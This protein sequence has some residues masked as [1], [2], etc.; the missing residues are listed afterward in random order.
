MKNRNFYKSKNFYGSYLYSFLPSLWYQ[1][2][3]SIGYSIGLPPPSGFWI[4]LAYGWYHQETRRILFCDSS[5]GWTLVTSFPPID[6]GA[7]SSLWLLILECFII[8]CLVPQTCPY[9]CKLFKLN[10]LGAPS[11]FCSE[12]NWNITTKIESDKLGKKIWP[13]YRRGVYTSFIGAIL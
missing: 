1:R 4:I 8:P 2:L 3:T 11:V 9:L 12:P 7:N 5:A 13:A 6:E 10:P